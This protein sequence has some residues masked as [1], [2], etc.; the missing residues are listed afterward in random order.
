MARIDVPDGDGEELY[1]LWGVNP[2]MGGAAAA[3]SM[4]AYE[5]SKVA[6]RE[7]E[8]VRMRIAQINDCPI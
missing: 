6:I 5:Q 3:F 2:E 8:L 7:R 1:R 4:A